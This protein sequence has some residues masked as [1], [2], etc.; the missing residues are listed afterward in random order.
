MYLGMMPIF[1]LF[2]LVLYD[3]HVLQIPDEIECGEQNNIQG[4]PDNGNVS[5]RRYFNSNYVPDF[6]S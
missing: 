2:P 5:S 1:S 4:D 3:M 6:F